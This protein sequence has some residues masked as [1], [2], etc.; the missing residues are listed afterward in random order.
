[1]IMKKILSVLALLTICFGLSAC[2]SV[3]ELDIPQ[4]TE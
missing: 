4:G 3:Q 1:M 2:G